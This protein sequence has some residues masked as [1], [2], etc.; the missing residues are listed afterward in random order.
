MCALVERAKTPERADPITRLLADRVAQLRERAG[1]NQTEFGRKM[2]ELRP[3]GWSRS[4]VAKFEKYQRESISIADLFALA[5]ALDVPPVMLLADPHH[6]GAVPITENIAVPPWDALL[7]LI[8]R[9]DNA[10]LPGGERWRS[11]SEQ[12][13]DALQIVDVADTIEASRRLVRLDSLSSDPIRRERSREEAAEADRARLALLA[14]LLDE[15]RKWEVPAPPVP[16][17]VVE[18]AV[19]LGVE[20]PEVEA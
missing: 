1:M 16:V 18:R 11:A 17:H 5:L 10:A 12:V 13:R 9:A 15:F 7:W 8:G 3:G 2:S 6:T 4:G 14:Y 19:E 20:L